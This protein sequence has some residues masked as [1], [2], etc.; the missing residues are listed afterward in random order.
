[1]TTGT[2][3]SP[4][5]DLDKFLSAAREKYEKCI[6]VIEH[7]EAISGISITT[8]LHH[9]RFNGNCQPVIDVLAAY[10]Y[11]RIIDY[12]LAMKNRP[13]LMTSEEAAMFTKEA[14]RLFINPT[15]K[16][17]DPD[18]TGEAGEILLYFLLETVLGAPQIV[19]KMDLKTNPK[20]ESHG[21]DGIHMKWNEPEDIVDLYFGESKL[22]QDVGQAMTAALA[23]I[24]DFHEKDIFQHE[25]K[26]V[27]KHFKYAQPK[28]QHAVS[29]LFDSG[30]PGVGVRVNHACLI[31]YNWAEYGKLPTMAQ[32]KLTEEFRTRYLADAPRLHQLLQTRFNAWSK[33][34]LRFEVFFLPFPTVQAFRDAFNKELK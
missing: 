13:A 12:C 2:K 5:E 32:Q 34:D 24:K 3:A 6:D 20:L 22:Y 19:A 27:T 4:L 23:S 10:L 28:I 31:G 21:S 1:M 8:R 33:K 16:P 17:D 15:P 7:K 29:E 14:K 26:M 18:K 30:R 11:G 25:C 9:L